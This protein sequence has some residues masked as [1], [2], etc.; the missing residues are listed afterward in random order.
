M[1][2][3]PSDL[4]SLSSLP[5][6]TVIDTESPSIPAASSQTGLGEAEDTMIPM[7]LNLTQGLVKE[8]MNP[9]DRDDIIFAVET[10]SQPIDNDAV[11]VAMLAALGG[12]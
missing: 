9:N 1:M 11:A 8:M 10:N 5:A 6:S 12:L 4:E 2:P 7:D 3:S